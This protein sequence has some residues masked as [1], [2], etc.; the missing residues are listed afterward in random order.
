MYR[1]PDHIIGTKFDDEYVILHTETG[2]YYELNH[3][4][5]EIWQMIVEGR[6]PQA[7][8]DALASR[9]D[10]SRD[11][12]ERDFLEL[13]DDLKANGI[14]EEIDE[15]PSDMDTPASP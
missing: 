5:A 3:V 11:V 8:V 6:S 1:V 12:L 14:L 10:T 4:G 7:I 15:G 9:Y 2:Y 13:V